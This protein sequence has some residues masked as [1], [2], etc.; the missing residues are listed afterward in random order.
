MPLYSVLEISDPPPVMCIVMTHNRAMRF[1]LTVLVAAILRSGAHAEPK[2]PT[3]TTNWYAATLEQTI[4]AITNAFEHGHYHGMLFCPNA[5]QFDIAKKRW[6]RKPATNQWELITDGLAMGVNILVPW[7][8]QRLPY[9]AQFLIHAEQVATNQ[10]EVKVTTIR[11]SIP[12][13]KELGMHLTWVNHY[14]DIPPVL[15]EEANI[16]ARI[17]MQ[18]QSIQAGHFEALPA[19]ADV[20]EYFRQPVK[21]DL[22]RDPE[23]KRELQHAIETE[24]NAALKA[25]LLRMLMAAT[26]A[27]AK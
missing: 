12:H 21:I 17:E 13:G 22:T 16:L 23:A 4:A 3:G 18:L 5:E 6:I 11:A 8:K 26:N 24:T 20:T 25:E 15:A 1:M 9:N 7:N 27:S 14:K 10:C 19:T 2:W